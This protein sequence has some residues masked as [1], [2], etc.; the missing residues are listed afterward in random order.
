MWVMN[1]LEGKFAISSFMALGASFVFRLRVLLGF[2]N[3]ASPSIFRVTA[4]Y[5]GIAVSSIVT[6]TIETV[7]G[8]SPEQAATV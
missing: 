2:G 1:A 5:G 6:H 3:V 8:S 7:G 4:G